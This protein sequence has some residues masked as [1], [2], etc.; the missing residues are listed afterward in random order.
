MKVNDVVVFTL[1]DNKFIGIIKNIKTIKQMN[2]FNEEEELIQWYE[3]LPF[4]DDTV[5]IVVPKENVYPIINTEDFIILNRRKDSS[6]IND[7]PA[8]QLA[9]ELIMS[10]QLSY[11]EGD[12][13]W[14]YEDQFTDLINN[15]RPA[16]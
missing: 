10:S 1:E 8:R 15:F 5:V 4:K 13:Y 6:C 3:I 16:Y 7:T 12:M 11:L 9:A 14:E 2:I